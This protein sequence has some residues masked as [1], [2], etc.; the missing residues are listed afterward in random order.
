MEVSSQLHV[1]DALPPLDNNILN[2][3]DILNKQLSYSS[4]VHFMYNSD[5]ERV[6]S[7]VLNVYIQ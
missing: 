1:P 4:T 5:E 3:C 7:V 2:M 6:V